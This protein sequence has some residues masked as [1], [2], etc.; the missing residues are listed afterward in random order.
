MKCKIVPNIIY[1]LAIGLTIALCAT[2]LAQETTDEIEE[3]RASR[4]GGAEARQELLSKIVTGEVK[5]DEGSEQRQ[6]DR[7]GATVADPAVPLGPNAPFI[8]EPTREKYLIALREYYSYH[9]AGLQH[10]RDVFKW[11]LFSSKVIFVVVLL[12]VFVGIYFAAVQ[13][14]IGL[15][16][17]VDGSQDGAGR[18]ERTEFSASLKGVKVSSPIL[19]VVILVISLA[20]FYLYLVYVYPIEDI[21]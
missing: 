16:R 9:V 2:L 15:G 11:Q 10:R 6:R 12:L 3:G 5:V 4:Q 19:G 18:D 14:H 13:F 20:F 1:S 8:D 17:K 21:F 7:T